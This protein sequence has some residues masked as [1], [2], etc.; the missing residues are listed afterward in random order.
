[1][2][3]S[4]EDR[5]FSSIAVFASLVL[6]GL[7]L[8][9][10][11]HYVFDIVPPPRAI[12]VTLVRPVPPAPP[13]KRPASARPGASMAMHFSPAGDTTDLGA[14]LGST[15]GGSGNGQDGLDAFDDAVRQRIEAEKSYPAGPPDMW[16]GCV[17][18]YQVTVNQE[19]QLLSYQIYPCGNPF[20]ESAARAAILTASPYPVP[21]NFGGSQYTVFGSLIYT[22]H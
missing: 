16:M 4:R 17:I 8:W 10:L 21:P 19:G 20:L 15:A 13:A 5:R 6:H 1:M 18:E 3:A 12:T 7:L 11:L 9:L 14:D 2:D 22:H